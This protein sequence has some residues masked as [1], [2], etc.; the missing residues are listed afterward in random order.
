MSVFWEHFSSLAK[1]KDGSPNKTA[2]I[3]GLSSGSITAWSKG[4]IPTTA[5]I[6]KI[7]SHFGITTDSLLGRKKNDSKPAT[8]ADEEALLKIWRT[9]SLENKLEALIRIGNLVEHK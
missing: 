7:A 5:T 9:L 1:A 2:Q 3:L 8:T 4:T 6:E